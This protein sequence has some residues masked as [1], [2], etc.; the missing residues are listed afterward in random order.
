MTDKIAQT[1]SKKNAA[2]HRKPNTTHCICTV[3]VRR[4][5]FRYLNINISLIS[6][7]NQSNND[8]VKTLGLYRNS[9]ETFKT[10]IN[11]EVGIGTIRSIITIIMDY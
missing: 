9:C 2:Q 8:N 11:N 5:H 3:Q 7:S 4:R 1:E 10:T 6:E